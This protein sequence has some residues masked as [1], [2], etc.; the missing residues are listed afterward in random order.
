MPRTVS[1]WRRSSRHSAV[2]SVAV[3][4][5]AIAHD[6]GQPLDRAG[7]VGDGVHLL[8]VHQLEAVFDGA[9]EGVGLHQLLGVGRVHVAGR[10]HLLQGQQ[11]VGRA[12]VGVG[13][14]V[15]QLEQ[16]DGELDVADATRAPLDL[17]LV[18]AA[19]DDQLLGPVL[20][21]SQ[22]A[23]VVGAERVAPQPTLGRLVEAQP[24]RPVARHRLGLEQGLELPGFGPPV[25]VGLVGV[26]G[27][28]QTPVATLRA[29]VGVDPEAVSGQVHDLAGRGLQLGGRTVAHEDEVDVARVVELPA[30]ELAHPDHRQ[31][32]GAAQLAG[33]LDHVGGQVGQVPP[34]R[35]QVVGALEVTGRD[36]QELQLLPPGQ[37]LD[38]H[39]VDRRPAI[40]VA[41]HLQGLGCGGDQPG[42]GTAGGQHRHQASATLGCIGQPVVELRRAVWRS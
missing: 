36:P 42:Q 20:H 40:D 27:A 32:V 28:H 4:G 7:L 13:V 30:A 22:R 16:L 25:P 9:Q 35:G 10:G 6:P 31:P 2:G 34:H 33:R 39:G 5:V 37:P 15:D 29:Q 3:G 23:Q 14:T 26:E 21:G 11:R 12:D 19:S 24:Q 17:A 18:E 1:S 41:Q 38:G 8:L